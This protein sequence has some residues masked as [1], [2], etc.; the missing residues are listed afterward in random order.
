MASLNE[1]LRYANPLNIV[2]TVNGENTLNPDVEVDFN[3][4]D[5]GHDAP[6]YGDYSHNDVLR[7]STHKRRGVPARNILSSDITVTNNLPRPYSGVGGVSSVSNFK[8]ELNAFAEELVL[9]K[10]FDGDSYSLSVGGLLYPKEANEENLDWDDYKTWVSGRITSFDR[11]SVLS[12]AGSSILLDLE[13]RFPIN[14]H[15]SGI[16]EGQ[17]KD[18]LIGS[19]RQHSPKPVGDGVFDFHDGPISENADT[20]INLYPICAFEEGEVFGDLSIN[21][22]QTP[23]LSYVEGDFDWTA[24]NDTSAECTTPFETEVSLSGGDATLLVN[25]DGRIVISGDAE[26]SEVATTYDFFWTIVDSKTLKSARDFPTTVT[27]S[28]DIAISEQGPLHWFKIHGRDTSASEVAFEFHKPVKNAKLTV[29]AFRPGMTIGNWSSTPAS[30]TPALDGTNDSSLVTF[31]NVNSNRLAFDFKGNGLFGD[32]ID[33]GQLCAIWLTEVEYFDPFVVGVQFDFD[34][35]VKALTMLADFDAGQ[36][37]KNFSAPHQI[38]SGTL[39][40]GEAVVSWNDLNSNFLKMEMSMGYGDIV[41]ALTALTTVQT[42]SYGAQFSEGLIELSPADLSSAKVVTRIIDPDTGDDTELYRS[43]RMRARVVGRDNLTVQFGYEST[44]SGAIDIELTRAWQEFESRPVDTRRGRRGTLGGS[45]AVD[46]LHVLADRTGGDPG[47]YTVEISYL[48]DELREVVG[49]KQYFAKAVRVEDP[50]SSEQEFLDTFKVPNIY[51]LPRLPKPIAVYDPNGKA[52][53]SDTY[54]NIRGKFHGVTAHKTMAFGGSDSPNAVYVQSDDTTLV[55]GDLSSFNGVPIGGMVAIRAD[56]SHHKENI[57][58]IHGGFNSEVLFSAVNPENGAAYTYGLYSEYSGSATLDDGRFVRMYGLD[59]PASP[60]YGWLDPFWRIGVQSFLTSYSGLAWHPQSGGLIVYGNFTSFSPS[61]DDYAVR[62]I[63]S[64]PSNPSDDTDFAMSIA[65]PITNL[66]V[67]SD[68]RIVANDRL[69]DADG[70]DIGSLVANTAFTTH[71]A[72]AEY[73]SAT[74]VV[75]QGSSLAAIDY[76]GEI[77]G[78]LHTLNFVGGNISKILVRDGYVYVLG[79]FTHI[80]GSPRGGIARL[81]LDGKNQKFVRGV[82]FDGLVKDAAFKSAGSLVVVGD[83]DSLDGVPAH[84]I[85]EISAGGSYPSYLATQAIS[86]VSEQTIGSDIV[87]EQLG[88]IEVAIPFTEQKPLIEWVNAIESSSDLIHEIDAETNRLNIS[89]RWDGEQNPQEFRIY[90]SQLAAY[91]DGRLIQRL[92]S[93]QPE[94]GYAVNYWDGRKGD[95][96]PIDS[97]KGDVAP[98]ADVE[99]KQINSYVTQRA[100]ALYLARRDRRDAYGY[101]EYELQWIGLGP[102]LKAGMV[103]YVYVGEVLGEDCEILSVAQSAGSDL[104]K[105][106]FAVYDIKEAGAR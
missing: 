72:V 2:L 57:G 44:S 87:A 81:T 37:V 50:R 17:A 32:S 3:G 68:G 85:A 52:K 102:E 10:I 18:Y 13:K 47:D 83:F 65:A 92:R 55:F 6:Y 4:A 71:D 82:G 69:L 98:I 25:D 19:H 48:Y 73:D 106:R 31:E 66:H 11:R 35:Q 63:P 15:T 97:V 67:L 91:S 7:F 26:V 89:R 38:V 49:Q 90:E 41:L 53:V 64:A 5:E 27:V 100:E 94:S 99:P 80:N 74:L 24:T 105:V 33:P 20:L 60:P 103:G 36:V 70:G 46:G 96:A 59:E 28:G 14:R 39:G 75:S 56:G 51:D 42:G 8:V 9:G 16:S 34:E 78:V 58:S 86:H 23:D 84:K 104:T 95:A 61:G 93:A 29:W 88:E 30:I 1:I 77:V 21:G 43:L 101:S 12:L 22:G 62:L 76:S 54:E 45:D 79:G 40:E